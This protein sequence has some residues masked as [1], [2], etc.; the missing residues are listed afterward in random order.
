[1]D[2]SISPAGNFFKYA[3]GKWMETHPIP[4]EYP[5]W[6]TFISLHD[7]NLS[8]LKEL[9]NG[10][11]P[12][13]GGVANTPA[14]KVAAFW[15]SVMDEDAVEQAGL[16]PLAP[17]LATCDLA[18]DD[19]TAA[20]AK[21]HAEYGV[22]VFF[23]TGEGPDD[24]KSEWTLVQLHQSGLGLPD[25]DY[26]FDED[27][28]EKRALYEA[29]IASSLAMLGEEAEVAKVQAAAVMKLETKLAASHLTRSERRDPDTCYN[30]YSAAKLAAL[31]KGAVE[32]P[33]YL[34][35]VGK[36]APSA[37]NID[38]PT[39]LAVAS[40]LLEATPT[41][42]L[43]AYLRWH[44]C[45]A[46]AQHLPKAFVDAHFEFFSKAL[47][48]QQEQKPRWKRAMAFV[49]DA[50]GEAVGELYVEK[51]FGGEAKPRALATVENVRAA[52][53][54]RLR[55]VEWM[56]ESTREKALQKMNEF[57]VKIGYPDEWVDYSKLRIAAGDHLGN[58]QRALAFE[59]ARQ[60]GYADAPTDRT[61]WLMLPQQ[62]NAYYHPNLNEIVFPA[63][64]LQ[65]PFFDA[66][67]DDAVNFGAMGAVVGHEMTHGFDDQGRQ[68]DFK[69]NLNDWWEK[70]D[71]EE[72]ERRVSVQVEQA[73]RFA[74]YG[75]E[76][77]GKL[78]CGENIADLGGL[79][80]AFAALNTQLD[81]KGSPGHINGFDAHQRFFLS[82]AQVWRENTTKE[83]ALQ[84]VTLDPH[85]PN[86]YRVNGPLTNMPEFH[87][88]FGVKEGDAMWRPQAER[89]DIW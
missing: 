25:R 66:T 2:P 82:W 1:M 51:Y 9:L 81:A 55:E 49:E 12:P 58:V 69:G 6:N 34:E 61:R 88:A 23:A 44:V 54:H 89:V 5:A 20:V 41:D 62:I 75:K 76:L 4:A 85:G 26:Y 24:K 32:W 83:R 13:V 7:S 74:V 50:L 43:R 52:L 31:V 39:A 87:A 11:P 28:A 14:E 64:I 79:K 77:N 17:I 71:G 72:Y 35:L 46:Y 30:K 38:S 33:R 67:A 59:H 48:G 60:M 40:R 53:E 70:A 27:K 21:L 63:A 42:E 19:K 73:S 57:N 84:M 47:S 37:V 22:N 86:E 18:A 8:R 56:A 3:N 45:K 29:H 16:T 80:L 65:P 10:L 78:T 15:H 68:Y 36:P